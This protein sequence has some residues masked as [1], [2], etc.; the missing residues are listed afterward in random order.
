[1]KS[2]ATVFMSVKTYTIKV[3]NVG[4]LEKLWKDSYLHSKIETFYAF[5][6]GRAV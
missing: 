5:A 4:N 1:M 2:V 3:L 6:N